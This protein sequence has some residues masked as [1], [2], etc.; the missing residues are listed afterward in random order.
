MLEE[1]IANKFPAIDRVY[2]LMNFQKKKK[3]SQMGIKN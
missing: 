3:L 2:Q 1:Q